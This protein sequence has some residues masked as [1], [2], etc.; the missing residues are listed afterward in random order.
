[1]ELLILK[2][3]R[4]Q[5]HFTSDSPKVMFVDVKLSASNQY[6]LFIYLIGGEPAY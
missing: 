1:M 6:I 4:I 2:Y 5:D 3:A